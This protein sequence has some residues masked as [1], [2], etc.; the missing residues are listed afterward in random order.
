MRSIALIGGKLQ[1]FEANYLAKKAGIRVLLIDRNPEALSR[2]VVDDFHCFDIIENPEKLIE[3][4]KSVDGILPVNENQDTLNFLRNI[5]EELACPLLFDFD[6]YHISMDKK[7]SKEYFNSIQIP[8]PLDRPSSPP[9]FIKP[10]CESSSSGT[11]IIYDDAGLVGLDPSMLIEEYVKGDVVSLEVIGDGEHFAVF[12]ETKVHIDDGYDCHMVTPIDKY[13]QFREISYELAKNMNLRGIMDVE[14]IDSPKGLKVL[15]IDARLPSQTPTVV[16]H[17]SGINLMEILLQ[18][19]LEGVQ[20]ENRHPENQ[21]CIFEHLTS[22]DDGL[23]G[24]GE[25]VLSDGNDYREFYV[26]DGLEIF[27][28]TGGEREVFTLISWAAG[29]V[30]TEK[31]RENGLKII[32]NYLSKNGQGA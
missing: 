30:E 24:V 16:Y 26:S 32:N 1:G 8:T 12:K 28:C 21:Y 29:K 22:M 19:F 23:V 14:A 20:E 10:P 27:H 13:P 25:H 2:N 3:I 18:A 15:E 6:A 11:A 31:K 9:Y 5:Q 17:S 7:R 4:S